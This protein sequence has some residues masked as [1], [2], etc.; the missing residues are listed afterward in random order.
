MNTES[1]A[2]IQ[3]LS[4]T[5][6]RGP[7]QCIFSEG[8]ILAAD[9]HGARAEALRSLR[10]QLME[11]H[12]RL[13]RRAIALCSPGAGAGTSFMAANLAVAFARAGANTLLIDANMRD[14]AVQDFIVPAQPVAGL[15]Q[16][17]AGNGN[18]ADF[19]QGNAAPNLSILYSGGPDAAALDRLSGPSF[20]ALMARCM[21]DFDLV[22]A[23]TPPAN[24]HADVLRI[25]A[26]AG[27]ALLVLRKHVSF[28]ADADM[29]IGQLAASRAGVAGIV[30]NEGP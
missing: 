30:L 13:G 6:S 8:V 27:H 3:E 7:G 5:V 14:P 24:R 10:T 28:M 4:E 9:P 21:R 11:R 19:I 15:A 18:C 26:A 2:D 16:C 12:L 29:L 22:I 1:I 25:A 20:P 17:L 23:D